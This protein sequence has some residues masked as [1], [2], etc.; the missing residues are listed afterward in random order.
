[1]VASVAIVPMAPPPL[2]ASLLADVLAVEISFCQ[3]ASC[4]LMSL[5]QIDSSV[6]KS[7]YLFEKSKRPPVTTILYM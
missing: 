3:F 5:E 2:V 6:V 1:V 7:I 4:E